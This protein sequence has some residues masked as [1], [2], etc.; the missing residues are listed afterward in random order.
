MALLRRGPRLW[1]WSSRTTAD[2]R[3]A[4]PGERDSLETASRA[5]TERE[6][7]ERESEKDSDRAFESQSQ[8]SGQCHSRVR[9]ERTGTRRGRRRDPGPVGRVGCRGGLVPTWVPSFAAR[10]SGEAACI[11]YA[12]RETGGLPAPRDCKG[13]VR[14]GRSGVM[15]VL[16]VRVSLLFGALPPV[17]IDDQRRNR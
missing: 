17:A 14:V 13:L 8:S 10:V 7:V 1:T 6:R 12:I 15:Y 9:S 11:R 5:E 16:Y 3:C 4:S 2:S